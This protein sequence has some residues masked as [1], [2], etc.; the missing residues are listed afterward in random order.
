MR[1]ILVENARCKLR[2]RHGGQHEWV[3]YDVIDLPIAA[4][5]EKGLQVHE[6][7]DRLAQI[8]PRK[9][10]VVKMRMF[11]GLEVREIAAA[12]NAS[13]RTVQRDWLFAKAWLSR[14]LQ[15]EA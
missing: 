12:L 15:K 3:D 7:L 14:E 11:I 8:D 10:D 1:R 2:L 9:A 4:D 5:D 6:A 13:E